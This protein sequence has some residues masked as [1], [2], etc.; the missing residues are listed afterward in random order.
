M[1]TVMI[2]AGAAALA[3]GATAIAATTMPYGD[4]YAQ[5][6][7]MIEDLQARYM[8]A[9]DFRDADFYAEVFTE[10]A[11]LT[12]GNGTETGREAIHAFLSA[13]PR[14]TDEPGLRPSKGAHNITNIVIE[15]DGN[16]ARSVAYWVVAGNNNPERSASVGAY[17]HYEDELV[18]IDGQWYFSKREIYN[19]QLDR[20]SAAGQPNPVRGLWSDASTQT[21]TETQAAPQ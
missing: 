6:R 16:R 19:E 14:F 7:A 21:W 2:A 11:T 4:D 12:H 20:R 13:P 5:D 10:D 9:M 18:K 15:V 8:F 3:A 1:R 17:G